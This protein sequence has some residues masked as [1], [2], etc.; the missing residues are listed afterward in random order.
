MMRSEEGLGNGWEAMLTPTN[1]RQVRKRS[2]YVGTLDN[3]AHWFESG[4]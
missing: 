1:G 3:E 4:K 2:G